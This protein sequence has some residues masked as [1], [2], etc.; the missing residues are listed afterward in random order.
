MYYEDMYHPVNRDDESINSDIFSAS[1]MFSRAADRHRGTNKEQH[2]MKMLDKGYYYYYKKV[3]NQKPLKI[4]LY[5]SGNALGYRIRDPITGAKLYARIGSKSEKEFFK[6]RWCSLNRTNPVT[7]FYDSPEQ[8]EKHHRTSLPDVV[9]EKWWNE[10][11]GLEQLSSLGIEPANVPNVGGN[12]STKL[13]V[14]QDDSVCGRAVEPTH[15]STNA[16]N[17]GSYAKALLLNMFV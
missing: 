7:L 9:K 4:E 2:E 5:D 6:V 15:R 10:H 11:R 12:V 13:V 8:Y 16:D 3:H 17:S 14:Q 1:S